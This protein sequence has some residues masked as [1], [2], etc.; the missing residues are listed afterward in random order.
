MGLRL[1][2]VRY[3]ITEKKSTWGGDGSK[4]RQMVALTEEASILSANIL[5]RPSTS[6][7][8]Q[9]TMHLYRRGAQKDRTKGA[10]GKDVR[11][12]LLKKEHS[13]Q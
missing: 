10:S 1:D 13:I 11:R 3:M 4:K 9:P 2:D 7:V 8:S 6:C 12:L 5:R